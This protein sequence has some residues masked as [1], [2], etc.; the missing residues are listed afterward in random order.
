MAVV[1]LVS[2][3]DNSPLGP[4][5]E[6]Y[7]EGL[8]DSICRPYKSSSGGFN[9][10]HFNLP[11]LY[12]SNHPQRKRVKRIENDTYLIVTPSGRDTD[13][14]I[15]TFS[16]EQSQGVLASLSVSIGDSLSSEEGTQTNGLY[17][18]SGT[19][20]FSGH[21]KSADRKTIFIVLNRLQREYDSSFGYRGN[22][23]LYGKRSAN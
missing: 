19:G 12:V 14:R 18:F 9:T 17:P 20:A 13:A 23:T 3:P 16:N 4:I 7:H 11:D 8:N 6:R 22:I 1:P 5:E 15:A 21:Y 10:E 2:N